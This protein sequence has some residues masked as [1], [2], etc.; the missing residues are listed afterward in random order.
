VDQLPASASSGM[1]EN[2][3][4]HLDANA[5]VGQ[6]SALIQYIRA[7]SQPRVIVSKLCQVLAESKC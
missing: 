1:C 5:L 2:D 7:L 4:H 6:L 3:M